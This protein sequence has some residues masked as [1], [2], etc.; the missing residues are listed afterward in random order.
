MVAANHR[1]RSPRE[2]RDEALALLIR[3]DDRCAGLR[4]D[5]GGA[6]IADEP[7]ELDGADWADIR[8]LQSELVALLTPPTPATVAHVRALYAAGEWGAARETDRFGVAR[9]LAGVADAN[10]AEGRAE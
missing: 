5:A 7:Y 1:R 6:I 8:M 2:R 9:F 4:V 3:L 10:T